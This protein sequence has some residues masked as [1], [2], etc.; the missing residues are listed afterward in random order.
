M[1]D[2][3]EIRARDAKFL[4]R[5]AVFIVALT[6]S[7]LFCVTFVALSPSGIKYADIAVPLLLGTVIGG[8]MGFWYG[9]S[10][11]QPTPP[12]APLTTGI[13]VKPLPGAPSG[14][15]GDPIAVHEES[16]AA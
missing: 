7:Y 11:T 4:A 14:K 1:I 8:L 10:K 15:P 16:P 3:T 2:S 6:F 12:A 13:T 5:F 9:A